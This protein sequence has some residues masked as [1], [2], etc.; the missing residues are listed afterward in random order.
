MQNMAKHM[1]V[2]KSHN[3][4]NKIKKMKIKLTEEEQL[5]IDNY[6]ENELLDDKKFVKG[7]ANRPDH[8]RTKQQLKKFEQF[9]RKVEQGQIKK[10]IRGDDGYEEVNANV[11]DVTRIIRLDRDWSENIIEDVLN[12]LRCPLD[13]HLYADDFGG[14]ENA[15]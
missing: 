14:E 12:H 6:L 2:E 5:M 1:M 4:E 3:K 15:D 8:A 10:K 11:E 9:Q 7:L 13:L